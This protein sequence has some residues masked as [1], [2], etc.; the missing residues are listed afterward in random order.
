MQKKIVI[1]VDGH[2]SCGKSTLAK[3]IAGVLKITYIDSGAMYRGATLLAL[4]SGLIENDAINETALIRLVEQS[5]MD[6]H[7]I[8]GKS[9]LLLNGRDV[10][11][12]IRSVEVSDKVSFVARLASIRSILVK[13]QQA[14]GQTKSVIMDG[15]D[16]GTVVFPNAD[17]KFF[18]TAAP[19][20]RAQR[21]YLELQSMGETVTYQQVLENITKRDHIDQNREA[22]PLQQ[23]PDAVVLD[24]SH[25]TREQQ[26]NVA[27]ETIKQ[28]RPD[29][30]TH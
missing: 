28:K 29:F 5:T 7:V 13:R 6:F 18:V 14:M 8:E 15:R 24:N 2:S 17:V 10:E 22:S 4:Q 3:D 27:L 20:I 21:R 30:F 1:A 25:L 23:T 19:E 26:L 12:E 11:R 16:I 9:R